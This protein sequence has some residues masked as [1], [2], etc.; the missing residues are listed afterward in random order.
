M[1]YVERIKT[2][3]YQRRIPSRCLSL[4]TTIH[5]LDGRLTP[6]GNINPFQTYSAYVGVIWSPVKGFKIVPEV[7]YAKVTT[8]YATGATGAEPGGKSLDAW[9]GRIQVRRDF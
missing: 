4:N 2:E 1:Q 3:I 9:Q 7:N 6:A 8:K 5:L